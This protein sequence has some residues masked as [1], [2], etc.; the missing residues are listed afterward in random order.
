MVKTPITG[1]AGLT[2]AEM[3]CWLLSLVTNSHFELDGGKYEV[4]D[5][6]NITACAPY[7]R[8][9]VHRVGK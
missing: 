3:K 1:K 2:E 4:M 9:V 8:L 6:F 7:G 5:S